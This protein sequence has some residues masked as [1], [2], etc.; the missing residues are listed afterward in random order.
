AERLGEAALFG[1]TRY[2]W[3]RPDVLGRLTAA[4]LNRVAA[5]YLVP[6]NCRLMVLVPK[7]TPDLPEESKAAFHKVFDTLKGP[8]N[9]GPPGLDA[10][11][12]PPSESA[13]VDALA[14]GKGG[15]AV[16][17]TPRRT[18]LKNGLTL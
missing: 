10:T 12:Y 14:W 11:L 8:D 13:K 9:A 15:G 4:E 16:L 18:A 7:G 3:D 6:E 2:Y 1:G 17:G 5:K